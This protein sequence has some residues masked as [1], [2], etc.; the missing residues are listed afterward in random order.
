MNKN[1]KLNSAT[2]SENKNDTIE[3]NDNTL[4]NVNG[5]IDLNYFNSKFYK[6]CPSCGKYAFVALGPSMGQCR[7]CN[8]S[9][10]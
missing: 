3:L 10:S 4:E 2:P 6:K 8:Y 5:G 9:K 1:D 7:E